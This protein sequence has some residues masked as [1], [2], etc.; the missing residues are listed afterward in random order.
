[1]A[2]GHLPVS[3]DAQLA[4]VLAHRAVSA[5]ANACAAGS[6]GQRAPS[7]C[8]GPGFHV[9]CRVEAT[10]S[11][12]TWRQLHPRPHTRCAPPPCAAAGSGWVCHQGAASSPSWCVRPLSLPFCTCT[13][14][15]WLDCWL[16][17]CW[18]AT[19]HPGII[20]SCTI[21]S[22]DPAWP[23]CCFV[24]LCA[25]LSQRGRFLWV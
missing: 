23:V 25:F 5:A 3:A 24:H 11:S 21:P 12:P 6:S 14:F 19:V 4:M 20:P 1:V 17:C 10:C 13:S 7:R 2:G 8:S 22:C 9:A 18:P 16:S 15:T